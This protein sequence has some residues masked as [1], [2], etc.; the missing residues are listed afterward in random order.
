MPA[1]AWPPRLPTEPPPGAVGTGAVVHSQISIHEA[2]TG[3]LV[4]HPLLTV[5]ALTWYMR[6]HTY[7][8][9]DKKSKQEEN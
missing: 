7:T 4:Q 6:T 8:Q 2:S 3:E 5:Q 1:A 9:L